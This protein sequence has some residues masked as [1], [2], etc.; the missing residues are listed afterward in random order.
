MSRQLNEVR[1]RT[2]RASGQERARQKSRAEALSVVQVGRFRKQGGWRP[3][4]EGCAGQWER[5]LGADHVGLWAIRR[6]W[7][8]FSG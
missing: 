4:G 8:I 7:R 2:V 5:E 1:E 3:S 6:L